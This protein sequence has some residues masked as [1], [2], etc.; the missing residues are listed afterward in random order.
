M[1]TIPVSLYQREL[2]NRNQEKIDKSNVAVLEVY[3]LKPS[4]QFL[5]VEEIEG[6]DDEYYEGCYESVVNKSWS[7]II[8][9]NATPLINFIY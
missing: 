2:E 5:E 1:Y 4:Y 9:P 8:Y 3:K 6:D 7:E